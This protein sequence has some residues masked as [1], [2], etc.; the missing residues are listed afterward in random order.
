GTPNY[1]GVREKLLKQIESLNLQ[2]D[3]IFAGYVS[4]NELAEIYNAVD[5]F[6][7]P[8]L[9]EGFGIPPLEAMAC[10]TPVITSNTSS[11][12]EVV[13]DAAIQADP[14]NTEK[15]VEEMYEVLTNEDLKKEMIRKGLKRS[16]VFSWDNSAKKTLKVYKE[17]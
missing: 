9:Y 14:Y 8:S 12:P 15:F 5:L 13:G 2:K 10:G 1:L 17:L 16:K 6:V 11:L 3:I 7:F 4:E